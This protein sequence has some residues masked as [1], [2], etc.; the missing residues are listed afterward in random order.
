MSRAGR[1]DD[2][3][4][5]LQNRRAFHD[6]VDAMCRAANEREGMEN[7]NLVRTLCGLLD[8]SRYSFNGYRCIKAKPWRDEKGFR[9]ELK[10]ERNGNISVVLLEVRE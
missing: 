7:F 8:S 6:S 9:L 1:R 2:A 3:T 4:Y 5:W 10:D